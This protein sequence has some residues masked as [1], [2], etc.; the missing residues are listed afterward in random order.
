M[1]TGRWGGVPEPGFQYR[2]LESAPLRDFLQIPA[3]RTGVQITSVA[4]QGALASSVKRGD[5]LMKVDGQDVS[6]EGTVLLKLTSGQEL[7]LPL[8]H[9]RG[10]SC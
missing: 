6:N 9:L 7:Q 4:P 3:G 5:V 10:K 1:N 8:E 2:L